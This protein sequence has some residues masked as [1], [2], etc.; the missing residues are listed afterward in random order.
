MQHATNFEAEYGFDLTDFGDN[1][2]AFCE[3]TGMSFDRRG[4]YGFH[5]IGHGGVAM[6]TGNN[7]TTGD[8]YRGDE[9]HPQIGYASYIGISGPADQ[10]EAVAALVRAHATYIK[11]VSPG[12]RAFI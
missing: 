3:A 6:T 10:V 7:P 1:W 4:R 9:R 8:F 11:D 5:W 2:P 12:R